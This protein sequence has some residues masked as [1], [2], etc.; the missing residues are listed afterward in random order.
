MKLYDCA[1]AP[2]P[3]RTRIFIAEKDLDIETVQV[4]LGSGEQ[5]SDSFRKLNPR[6]TVPVLE[7]DDGRVLTENVAIAAYLESVKPEPPLMGTDPYA[8]ALVL[9][10]NARVEQEGML[11][12]ME[13]FR[14]RS[15]G[16]QDRALTGPRNY[17]QIP[18]LV[19]RG[20][21][22][23]KDFLA[24]LD[25]R[26]AENEFICGDAFGLADITATIAVEFAG[27]IKVE[28]PDDAANLKRWFEAVKQRP[29]YAA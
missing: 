12:I 17:A 16:L 10:W 2:S 15:K 29:S 18:D 3:R 26:L 1:P 21:Q 4:D 22:R 7:L 9:E 5:L 19:E 14:N 13:A 11:A 24:V 8:R 27:R 20:T 23:T 6:C 28:I 25:E